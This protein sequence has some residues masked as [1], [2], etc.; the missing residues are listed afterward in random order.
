MSFAPVNDYVRSSVA[1]LQRKAAA[2]CNNHGFGDLSDEVYLIEYRLLGGSSP[3]SPFRNRGAS[4]FP[5]APSVAPG[6]ER[7]AMGR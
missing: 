4:R 1:V 3:T 2:D 5:Q 6:R 7:L